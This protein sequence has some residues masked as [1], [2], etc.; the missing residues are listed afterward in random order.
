TIDIADSAVVVEPGET[1]EAPALFRVPP[2]TFVGAT[3]SKFL[4]SVRV[5]GDDG[6]E[7]MI[8]HR[9][10]GPANGVLRE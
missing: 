5:V 7:E 3:D 10:V 6:F 9:L 4:A 1:V 8:K 2:T